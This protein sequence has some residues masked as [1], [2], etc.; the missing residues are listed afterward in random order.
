MSAKETSR[1]WWRS[2]VVYEIAAISFQDSDGDGY[3]DLP[4]LLQR[5]DYLKWLGV[6]VV[7]LTPIYKSPDQDFGYDIS[8]FCGI[9]P[10]YGTMQDFERVRDALHA[11]GIKLILDF[12]PNHTSDQHAWFQE[13]RTSRNNPKADWYVWAKAGPN[14]GPPNNWLSRFG[15][16]G[17]EWCDARRQFYYH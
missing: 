1:A 3:G 12:V 8:D 13:S 9:D 17:W 7:W 10:R 5:I 11:A 15:G 4:G 14:G 2:A 6:G 16:S